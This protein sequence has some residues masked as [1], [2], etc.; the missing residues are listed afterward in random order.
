MSGLKKFFFDDVREAPDKDWV[1]ARDVSEAKQVLLKDAFDVMSLEHDIG[2]RTM[3][4]RC[5]DDIPKPITNSQLEEKLRLGCLHREHG[6]DLAT[7]MVQNLA[8]WPNLI[9]IHSSNPYGAE[10]MKAILEP[11]AD[12]KIIDYEHCRYDRIVGTALVYWIVA[13]CVM[14][15]GIIGIV[16]GWAR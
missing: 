2:M 3:C 16:L 12:I 10:R 11:H 1:V 5:Y 8:N 6:T 9:I 4:K 15:A 7:W 14:A 13:G